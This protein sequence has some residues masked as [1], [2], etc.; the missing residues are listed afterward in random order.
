MGKGKMKVK[1]GKTRKRLYHADVTTRDIVIFRSLAPGPKT[2]QQIHE[3]LKKLSREPCDWRESNHVLII[4]TLKSRI[5]KLCRAGY[6]NSVRYRTK[7]GKAFAL[8][9]LTSDSESE[10][11][12]RGYKSR[13]IRKSFPHE[14]T[15]GHD[16]LVVETIERIDKE[17]RRIRLANCEIEMRVDYWDENLLKAASAGG[18]KGRRYPD[19]YLKI[20]YENED[21]STVKCNYAMEI[22][23]D[24]MSPMRVFEKT[25]GI[26]KQTEGRIAI[27]MLCPNSA[28]I[29]KLQKWF[30]EEIDTLLSKKPNQRPKNLDELKDAVLFCLHSVFCNHGFCDLNW[31][32]I[33]GRSVCIIRSGLTWQHLCPVA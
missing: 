7:T 2:L 29:K 27:L 8:Y 28:R 18:K 23:N 33:D 17:T 22:D 15:V 30:S 21:C 31:D 14:R 9:A 3:S 25:I 26:F 32:T 19:L 1:S 5:H 10:L 6:L 12:E 13:H 16:K 4:S 20:T 11:K 24:S